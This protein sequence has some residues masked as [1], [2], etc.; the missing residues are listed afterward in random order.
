MV[1]KLKVA[2][3]FGMALLFF[4]CADAERDGY[5]DPKSQN[6]SGDKGV[7]GGIEKG[8]SE[9]CGNTV[10]GTNTVA[11]GGQTYKTVQIGSQTWMAENLNY[12]GDNNA[13]KNT[14]SY[15]YGVLYDWAT[16]MG[17]DYSCNN[18]NSNCSYQI[19][20]PYH[21]GI[22]PEGWH[23]PTG[24]EWDELF[25]FVEKEDCNTYSNS[26]K[27]YCSTAG[28]HLKATYGWVANG[29]G[30]D[31]YGF[32]AL[33]GGY[34]ESQYS[35]SQGS[36]GY[37]WSASEFYASLIDTRI[38]SYSSYAE[39][40][41]K[42]KKN[43][44]SVR[45]LK[46]GSTGGSQPF[47]GEP[48]GN[49]V[50]GANTIACGGQT[51]RTTPIGTQLWM[52]ENLNYNVPN[53]NADVCYDK[54]PSNC[55][56]YG[57]L[58]DWATAMG[59]SQSCNSNSRS[60]A[61][62]MQSPYHRGICPE[63][64]HIPSNDDWNQLYDYHGDDN[65]LYMSAKHLKASG[66]WVNNGSGEDTY[67]F[68][69]L[70]GGSG[71]NNGSSEY[72][73]GNIGH[74][75]YW[76]S[77]SESYNNNLHY[78]KGLFMYSSDYISNNELSKSQ[79]VSVRCLRDAPFVSSS[80]SVSSSS[81]SYGTLTYDSQTYKTVK[82]GTQTWMAENLNYDVLE[83]TTDL[84]YDRNP[85]NC[86]TYGRLYDWSTAMG[87]SQNCNN[88]YSCADQ[89]QYK[90]RG[91]C[92]E[93]WY[94]PSDEDWDVLAATVGGA[95]TAGTILK[96]TSG[97]YNES[98]GEHNGNGTNSYGFSAFPGGAGYS[99]SFDGVG[100]NGYWWSISEYGSYGAYSRRMNFWDE[101]IYKE[102]SNKSSLF[103]VRCL[104]D[105]S[106]VSS[107]SNTCDGQTFYPPSQRC[108]NRVIE[109]KCGT[110]TWYN[111]SSENLLCENGIVKTRCGTSW[112]YYNDSD[113]NLRCENDI[114]ETK[115][116][117][118][119]YDATKD[120]LRCEDGYNLQELCGTWYYVADNRRC[121]N[122]VIETRCNASDPN[123]WYVPS[124]NLRCYNNV[125]ETKCGS[126]WYN[127]SNI[128]NERCNNNAFVEKRCGS[129]SWYRAS[130]TNLDCQSGVI[131][132]K[133]GT[134][135][136]YN[137]L[138]ENK[139]CQSN[140]VVTKCGTD[141]YD[142]SNA[143]L[144]CLSNV[145]QVNCGG[146]TNASGKL[147]YNNSQMVDKC[148]INPQAYNPSLYECK[149]DINP[150]GI[151]LKNPV[152]YQD[153]DYEAVLIGEQIW[154][155][156]NLNYDVPDNT[157]DVCYNNSSS[158]C[159]SYGRLYNW[160]TAMA[161]NTNCNSVTCASQVHSSKHR[162]ICPDGWHIP[163]DAEWTTLTNYVEIQGDCTNCA[164]TRLKA[165]SGWSS[166]GDGTD[167]YGFSALPGGYDYSDGYFHVA[168]Y[169]G[170]WWSSSEYELSSDI[171]YSRRMFYLYE[172]AN[173]YNDYKTG[174]F[175]VRCLQD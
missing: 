173:G 8:I 123:S 61:S 94:I 57:R 68:S 50:A 82:I 103:S 171:A 41:G 91:I 25:G 77:A 23:I 48:C 159:A 42:D 60:C 145:L 44:Y 12:Y 166:S 73:F 112:N 3:C 1:L 160:S 62:Q 92:P 58:Y 31:T 2:L 119:W 79:L 174:L 46:D 52:A 162:G 65:M 36:S 144:R 124:E 88:Y 90:H 70:P 26:Y 147:C 139:A 175:S 148:G 151:F 100:Y 114:I 141:W 35:C 43:R 30:E 17:F 133:C 172:Y 142:A 93:G 101:N 153:E 161:L 138:D 15:N 83:N 51:Y 158:Y 63:G 109:T 108:A 110:Y 97:W 140:V 167:D 96:N 11:C 95:S 74:Y 115:C 117:S 37:W 116:S 66:G 10:A 134:D 149:L 4:A 21:R 111:A 33:P 6:Y 59:F 29:R 99:S 131:V 128:A 7:G 126:E 125:I 155:A 118:R 13:F 129:N 130:D 87:F 98:G 20:E 5:N 170:Y 137:A 78:V 113:V 40:D 122:N 28:K 156:R 69:A 157:T 64:W 81:I 18:S 47:V 45:C 38:I 22:C 106:F 105:D 168:G 24:E 75:G 27:S 121:M 152:D 135:G 102:S 143:N 14:D 169:Q 76:W 16:A 49:T 39:R 53:N 164:G 127:A 136:W 55:A 107:S 154:M 132:T 67:G 150:N 163:S 89:I 86:T 85:S 34:C 9:P 165:T 72:Y 56:I 19:R 71:E 80:S 32:S 104:K 120:N 54:N 146:W 84:C